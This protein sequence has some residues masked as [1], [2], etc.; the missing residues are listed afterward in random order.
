MDVK[1]MRE[2][3][4]MTPTEVGV[5][6]TKDEALIIPHID[7]IKYLIQQSQF[8]PR[9]NYLLQHPEIAQ[10]KVK[11]L[12][13]ELREPNCIGT[14]LF[15]T[16]KSP[17][18]YPHHGYDEELEKFKREELRITPA[19][20][21]FCFSRFVGADGIDWHTGLCIGLIN[22]I[23]LMFTQHGAGNYFGVESASSFRNPEFYRIE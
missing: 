23:S 9:I 6:F 15:I 7:Q 1:F 19:K 4:K 10:I 14:T 17:L 3:L 20:D 5:I 8:S 2:Y 21:T 11:N 18:D 12:H 22:N 16:R 13:D